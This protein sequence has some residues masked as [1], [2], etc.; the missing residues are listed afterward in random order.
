MKRR[1][2]TL[3]VLLTSL[4]LT[5]VAVHAKSKPRFN[6]RGNLLI[7]DRYNNRVIEIDTNMQTIVW[8]YEMS[9]RKS[10]TN[11]I[12]GPCDAER[13][14]SQT[15]IVGG[16]LPP[17]ASTNYPSG[18]SDNRVILVNR[19]GRIIWQYGQA[20]VT[21]SGDNELNNPVTAMMLPHRSVLITDQGNQRVI[22]VN[23]KKK[24]VWQYGTTGVN[25]SDT[26]QLNQPAGAQRLGNGHYLIADAVNNRVI[27]VTR[28]GALLRQ[29][30]DPMDSSIL[31]GPTYVCRLS[32]GAN[33]LITDSLNNRIV[34]INRNNSNVFTYVTSA[35]SGSVTDPQPTHAVQ[36]KKGN[37]LIADQF[38]HQVIEIDASGDVVF[39]YGTLAVPGSADGFL[40]APCDAKVVGDYTGLTPLHG[41]GGGGFSFGFW[42]F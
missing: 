11:L 9:V 29:Y 14:H 16:G 21:G 10:V 17:G 15:L 7:V 8:Q 30:G 6:A 36:L 32:H 37:F 20:G 31:N 4:L 26:N 19:K 28:K 23:R 24:I 13:V 18:A 22:Q 40:N 42:S 5:A 35:R 12:V 41:S 27:E 1:T 33:L 38:N 3:G 34:E 2:R 39:S 25:G